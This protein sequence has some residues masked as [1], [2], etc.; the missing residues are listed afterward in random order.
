MLLTDGFTEKPLIFNISDPTDP[1]LLAGW[2]YDDGQ[3]HLPVTEEMTIAA[4][5]RTLFKRR[6]VFLSL[7]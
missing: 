1:K 6:E 2:Q 7:L 4:T 5:T 3:I